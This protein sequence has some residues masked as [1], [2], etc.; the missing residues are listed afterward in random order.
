MRGPDLK[1][2]FHGVRSATASESVLELC[3]DYQVRMAPSAFYCHVTAAVIFGVP[4]PAHLEASRTLRVAV[5]APHRAP[6]GKGIVGSVLSIPSSE[7]RHW[8]GLRVSSPAHTWCQLASVLSVPDL[9]AAGDHLIHWNRALTTT[10]ELARAVSA[11]AGQRGV[12][13]LRV[14]LPLLNDRSESRRESLLRLVLGSI[15]GV[16]ANLKITTSG[17]FEYRGDLAI[18]ER[19]VVIEYQSDYHAGTAQFR[20]DMTRR[21]RLEAD[22]WLVILVNADDLLD[23]RELLQRIGLAISRRPILA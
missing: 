10:A 4:L 20:R 14:A 8:R 12:Q 7:V 11:S 5:R 16:V 9:V 2:P 15:D 22:G 13:R 19:K 21:A 1:R 17:G 23:P 3:R 18:P 6:S